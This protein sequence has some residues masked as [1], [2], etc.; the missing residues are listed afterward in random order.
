M[1][2]CQSGVDAELESQRA[3]SQAIDKQIEVDAKRVKKEIK[4]LLLGRFA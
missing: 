4:I 2:N 3:R 1:G